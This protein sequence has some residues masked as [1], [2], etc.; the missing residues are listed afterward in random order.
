MKRVSCL[1]SVILLTSQCWVMGTGS[2]AGGDGKGD[3]MLQMLGLTA[4]F[5]I[6]DVATNSQGSGIT[7]ESTTLQL[8]PVNLMGADRIREL[9]A[10]S[11]DDEH[12]YLSADWEIMRVTKATGAPKTFVGNTTVPDSLRGPGALVRD[13]DY[14]YFYSSQTFRLQRTSTVDDGSSP[15]ESVIVPNKYAIQ[16]L[17]PNTLSANGTRVFWTVCESGGQKCSLKAKNSGLESPPEVLFTGPGSLSAT[18]LRNGTMEV[19]QATDSAV[20]LWLAP[21]ET[22]LSTSI[23]SLMR[24]DLQS[25]AVTT[26]QTGL[27]PRE[28]SKVGTS[29]IANGRFYW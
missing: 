8:S 12:L 21:P 27:S 22:P 1:I 10:I 11:S 3:A 6:R 16:P 23:A 4:A 18:I 24:Y 13:G 19:L 28:N 5:S 17:G 29:A 20:Y 2:D 15:V 9:N 14:A 26:L 7:N 25:R